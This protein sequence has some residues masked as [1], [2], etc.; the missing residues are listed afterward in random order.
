MVRDLRQGRGGDISSNINRNS[1]NHKTTTTHS[2]FFRATVRTKCWCVTSDKAAA[3]VFHQNRATTTTTTMR[4]A[5]SF[6][7][8]ASLTS[9]SLTLSVGGAIAL[10]TLICVFF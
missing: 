8:V 7:A 6:T 5:S 9:S 1:T 4:R 3:V 10:V 2:S